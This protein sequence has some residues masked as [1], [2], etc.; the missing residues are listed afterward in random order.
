MQPNVPPAPRTPSAHARK[1]V[2]RYTG[3]QFALLLIGV[4]FLLVGLGFGVGFNWGVWKDAAILLGGR[5]TEA[6]IESAELNRNVSINDEH[7]TT[8]RYAYEVDGVQYQGSTSVLDPGFGEN[9]TGTRVT[10]EYAASR[11]D[12]SRL[13]GETASVFGYFGLFALVFPLVGGVLFVTAVRSNRREIRAFSQGTPAVARVTSAGYDHSVKVNGS[14]P[15]VVRWEFQA[16]GGSFTG[17]LSSMSRDA[18]EEVTGRN[19]AEVVVLYLP[20]DPAT[21]TLWVD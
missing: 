6:T 2:Y 12:W 20:G 13:Q 14:H 5:T 18:L 9:P 19:P 16:E 17:S 10:I 4:V 7:P 15:F 11:H 1:L 21:N 3:T 8:V